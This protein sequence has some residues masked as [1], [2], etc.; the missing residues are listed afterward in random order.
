MTKSIN[1]KDLMTSYS[2]NTYTPSEYGVWEVF[3]EDPNCDFGG[4]HSNPKLGLLKGH[5][6]DCLFYAAIN[7]P[8]FY[9]WGYGG[10][11]VKRTEENM[12]EVPDNYYKNYNSD[13]EK[14]K[15]ELIKKKEELE[16]EIE[17]INNKLK[18]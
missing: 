6:Q 10:Y 5:F 14:E 4:P 1:I 17:K 8:R 12:V 2:H 3:G 7:L 18:G 13:L 11:L 15:R 16:K 9:T